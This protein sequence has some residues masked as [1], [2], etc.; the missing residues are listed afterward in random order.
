MQD[1]AWRGRAGAGDVD[2]IGFT[3]AY[4]PQPRPQA[5]EPAHHLGRP[6]RAQRRRYRTAAERRT[7]P[8]IPAR[9]SSPF[10]LNQEGTRGF[11]V[12]I[13]QLLVQRAM[14]V[15]SLDMYLTAGDA[16]VEFEEHQK[17]LAAWSGRRILD[18]VHR[19]PEASYEQYTARWEDMGDPA[20]THP[21][22]RGPGHIVVPYLGLRYRQV[23]H[24]PRRGRVER[25][26]QSGPFSVLVR[27]RRPGK[28]RRALLEGAAPGR[29]AAGRH[30]N[31]RGRRRALRSR[32][33]RL[34][35]GRPAAGAPRRHPDGADAEGEAGQPY[36]RSRAA[37]P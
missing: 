28:R 31:F 10:L 24:R 14:W 17:S 25:L 20:Y 21:Q 12:T 30:H 13:D 9:Q 29:R 34:P 23:R 5:P 26:R 11:S 16:P 8:F 18:S 15:P 33:V 1:G 7:P 4:T 3:L 2:G 27:L 22:Q 35:A 37:C 36:R 6:D 19:E 32:A